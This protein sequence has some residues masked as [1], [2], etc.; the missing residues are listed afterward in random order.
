MEGDGPGLAFADMSLS[1]SQR[2][3]LEQNHQAA[4]ITVG[5]DGRP[6]VARVGVCMVDGNLWSSGTQARVRTNRLRRDPRCTVFVFD[7]GWGWLALDT[8]V[9]VLDGPDAPELSLR[10][11]RLM[12]NRPDGPLSWFNGELSPEDFLRAM[13]DEQR[14][15]YQFEIIRGYGTQ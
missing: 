8:T 10:L 9:R 14:L 6:R 13:E 12:Q 11:F 7:S 1:D 2:A 5:Q 3:F 4:M 15:I